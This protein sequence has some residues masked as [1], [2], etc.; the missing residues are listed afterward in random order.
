MG[1]LD[2]HA[3]LHWAGCHGQSWPW[4]VAQLTANPK[5]GPVG[6]VVGWSWWWKAMLLSLLGLDGANLK[7]TRN[8]TCRQWR[9]DDVDTPKALYADNSVHQTKLC[10]LSVKSHSLLPPLAT[11]CL[12]TTILVTSHTFCNAGMP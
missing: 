9:N 8:G 4:L 6:A 2:Y 11:S 5:E 3:G 12:P 10:H 7:H 1:W